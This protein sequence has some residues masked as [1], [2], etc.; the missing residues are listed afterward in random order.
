[1]ELLRAKD[2]QATRAEQAEAK[3]KAAKTAPSIGQ[4]QF[5]QEQAELARKGH[6]G[7]GQKGSKNRAREFP[8]GFP[9][10]LG[11]T[12][13]ARRVW[14]ARGCG[15]VNYEFWRSGMSSHGRR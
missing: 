9:M 5:A 10:R 3:S 13:S 15:A 1:M 12:R 2:R 14:Q 7:G 8:G 6:R 4:D 11:R